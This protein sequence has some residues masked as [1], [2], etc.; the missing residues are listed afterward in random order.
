MRRFATMLL[1][2]YLAI[3]GFLGIVVLASYI[4]GPTLQLGI[5]WWLTSWAGV[6]GILQILFAGLIAQ[7][8]RTLLWL[9][10][11]AIWYFSDT[12]VSFGQWLAPGFYSVIT[13]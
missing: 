2:L 1:Q 13:N 7:F 4:L 11:L 12:G 9:P 3:G 10:S 6:S 5:F 8:V